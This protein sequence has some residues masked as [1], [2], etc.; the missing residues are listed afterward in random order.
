M[1]PERSASLWVVSGLAFFFWSYLGDGFDGCPLLG[2][3][4]II[5]NPLYLFSLVY[6]HM[7]CFN[8]FMLVFDL[9][10]SPNKYKQLIKYSDISP[11]KLLRMR[12]MSCYLVHADISTL[13]HIPDRNSSFFE[14]PF[15]TKAAAQIEAHHA[16]PW[17]I[18]LLQ[19]RSVGMIKIT[20][21]SGI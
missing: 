11:M 15:K 9:S 8:C 1:L 7:H 3:V 6:L 12:C 5:L 17:R 19:W 21:V 16:W 18:I 20:F 4:A 13:L 2:R 14:T 10:F